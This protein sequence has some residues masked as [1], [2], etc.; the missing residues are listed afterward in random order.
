MRQR[1]DCRAPR[2]R[3]ARAQP[4]PAAASRSRASRQHRQHPQRR[5]QREQP[6]R[7]RRYRP[8]A[9][10]SRSSTAITA[11]ACATS[12]HAPARAAVGRPAA[13]P[14]AVTRASMPNPRRSPQVGAHGRPRVVRPV[15]GP[16]PDGRLDAVPTAAARDSRRAAVAALH[17][18][19]ALDRPHRPGRTAA[20]HLL[21]H[22]LRHRPAQPLPVPPVVLAAR[23]GGP[24]WGYRAHP[25]PARRHRHRRDPAAA[26]QALVGL[27]QAVPVAAVPGRS[28]T[29]S[30]G[31][32]SRSWSRRRWSSSP[33]ASSTSWTGTRGRGTSCPCTASSAYVV[34]GSILLHIAVKLPD[35]RYG[36]RTPAGPGRRAHRD[37]VA[38]RTPTRTA[39]T[40]TPTRRRRRPSGISR[41]GVLVAAGAGI[42]ARRGHHRRADASRR[43]SAVGLLA[44]RRPARTPAAGVPVNRTAD[45]AK[46]VE[47]ATDPRWQLP[48]PG[49]RPHV[50]ARPWPSSRRCRV[51]DRASFPIACVEGWSVGA[52]WRGLRLLDLVR[53]VGRRRRLAGARDARSSRRA[54]TTLATSTGRRSAHALLATHLNGERL[55]LDHGYPLRLIAPDR[56]GVLNTK[57]LTRRG[58]PVMQTRVAIARRAGVAARPVRR[59]PAADARS[60]PRDL[61]VLAVWLVAALV[62]HDGDPV[63]A[64]SSASA[65]CW[66]GRCRPRARGVRPGG[67][68]RRRRSSP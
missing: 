67:A 62:L 7:V 49:R 19:A 46:V 31:S 20:R 53:Q 48:S 57:W 65:G 23:A 43:C 24:V 9:R 14:D 47:L 32:R 35:I 27:P 42:G 55:T 41:R 15:R 51:H 37:P 58:G 29:R 3:R 6:L 2:R 52:H 11:R 44:I 39:T 16:L 34:I 26:A 68:R 36:L 38:S 33:P 64:A 59:L 56:A 63:A 18:P 28:R 13:S 17:Q 61:V 40:T 25:G 10:R 22:L 8:R 12:D 1:G 54:R 4:R 45:Q 5:G 60:R 50:H 66:P 21:R 30:S